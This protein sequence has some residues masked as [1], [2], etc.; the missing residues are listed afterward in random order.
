L[1]YQLSKPRKRG[2]KCSYQKPSR[3]PLLLCDLNTETRVV[4]DREPEVLSKERAG[5]GKRE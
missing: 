1:G 5:Q 4:G 3:S 2:F